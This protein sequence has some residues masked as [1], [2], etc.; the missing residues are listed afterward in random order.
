M[1]FFVIGAIQIRD[2][3]D[4]DDV[5]THHFSGDQER[6]DSE[7]LEAVCGDRC[8]D[9]ET[10]EHVHC[11]KQRLVV[12]AKLSTGDDRHPR[13]QLR[14]MC[15]PHL[16]TEQPYHHQHSLARNL[17]LCNGGGTSELQHKIV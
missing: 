3:D 8:F 4:D 17:N 11:Q 1:F 16:S 13:D 10:I 15:L 9:E 14:A 12:K 5:I 2:D 7:Q 6:R